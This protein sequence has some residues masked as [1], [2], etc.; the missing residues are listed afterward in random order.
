MGISLVF[1][2]RLYAI[3]WSDKYNLLLAISIGLFLFV[4]GVQRLYTDSAVMS[5]TKRAVKI[6]YIWLIIVM[7][8]LLLGSATK[9]SADYSRLTMFTWFAV[10]PVLMI[11]WYTAL[12]WLQ[13]TLY[14]RGWNIRRVAIAGARDLGKQV[15]YSLINSHNMGMKPVGFY[16]DR[17]TNGPRPLVHDPL[18]IVGT[19]ED[20][21]RAAR[22]GDIDVVFIALP[23]RAEERIK[24]LVSKLSDTTAS[25]Y[26]VPDFFMFDLLSARWGNIGGLPVVSIYDTP[27]YGIDGWLKRSFDVVMASAILV[28]IALPMLFIA[29]AIKLTSPGPV[30]FKQRRYGINGEMIEVYKFRS[31][32]VT[33]EGDEVRQATKGDARVTKLGAFLRRT[34]L[35]ELPQFFNVLF[36]SMSIVGPRPHAVSHNEEYRGLISG[37][38]LRHKVKPG[39]TGL[40]QVNGWRGE[41]DT[42]EKMQKRIEY[43]LEYINRWS[44]WLDAK[45]VLKTITHGFIDKNAY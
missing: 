19:M 21:V 32:T 44:V 13:N 23:M 40:A 20:L 8:L 3:T 10:T 14:K 5:L 24:M 43:D 26:I 28:L 9:T 4:A 27:F 29:V 12:L 2:T 22:D 1:V 39:I 31:M 16:D 11:L 17:K 42:L 6:S 38:M 36:G 7:T 41:T 45:I 34:S 25:V 30:L 33:E 37:Y 35:D 18:P 15:A